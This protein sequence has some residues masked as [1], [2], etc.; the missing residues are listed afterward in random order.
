MDSPLTPPSPPLSHKVT[1]RENLRDITEATQ[2][3]IMVRGNYYKPGAKIPEGD[4][5]LYLYIEGPSAD[6]V[7]QAKRMLKAIVEEATEKALK[8]EARSVA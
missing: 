3:S 2:C 6:A 8:H 4:R 5:K 7:K 1:H